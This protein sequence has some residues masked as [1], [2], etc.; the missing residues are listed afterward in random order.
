MKIIA[1]PTIS[2]TDS[3]ARAT[4]P[5]G[6][7]LRNAAMSPPP[8]RSDADGAGRVDVGALGDDVLGSA[9]RYLPFRRY[10]DPAGPR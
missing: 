9:G 7:A 6:F 5:G 1:N 10:L 4:A 2:A 3:S 8:L